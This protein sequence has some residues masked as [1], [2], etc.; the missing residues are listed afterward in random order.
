MATAKKN[1]INN[2]E[3]GIF[4]ELNPFVENFKSDTTVIE[5]NEEEILKLK[6]IE[7]LTL[8]NRQSKRENLI[9]TIQLSIEEG[10]ETKSENKKK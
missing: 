9:E 4:K 8:L 1:G 2:A 10:K 6:E 7:R 5:I 3:L